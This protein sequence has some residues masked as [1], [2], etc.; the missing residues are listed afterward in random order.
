MKEVPR[1]WRTLETEPVLA[2]VEALWKDWLGSDLAAAKPFFRV[3]PRLAE[4]Y[5]CPNGGGSRCP[6]RVVDHGDDDFVAVCDNDEPPDCDNI[7]LTRA[8]VVI[9]RFDASALARTLGPLLSFEDA[10]GKAIDAVRGVFDLGQFPV[11]P[12]GRLPAFLALG[13]RSGERNHIVERLLAS[14]P[15]S[16]VLVVPTTQPRPE[17]QG[18][19]DSRSCPVLTCSDFVAVDPEHRMVAKFSRDEIA[20]AIT[21]RTAYSYR[22]QPP[23]PILREPAGQDYEA[24]LVG[25]LPKA[26][27]REVTQDEYEALIAGADSFEILVDGSGH[28][29]VIARRRTAAGALGEDEQLTPAEFGMLVGY[30]WRWVRSD[31]PCA[32]DWLA[33]KLGLSAGAH[34]SGGRTF[35]RMRDKV[36]IKLG[37]QKYRLF[38]QHRRLAGGAEYKFDPGAD[39]RFCVVARV[40]G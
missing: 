4:V 30:L 38:Q 18:L 25:F 37:G 9:H 33:D 27:G 23:A 34:G 8:D 31:A 6:R 14:H 2:G 15:R 17:V 5:P 19:L 21:G 16:F 13:L 36:D 22:L 7:R 11:A 40:P 32:P 10:S 12:G 39:V 20:S 1:L 28:G 3:E 24:Q 29:P 26:R 35:R